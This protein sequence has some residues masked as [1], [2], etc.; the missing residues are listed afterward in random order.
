V[1]QTLLI[2]A[3]L[4]QCGAVA[5]GIYLLTRRNAPAGAWLFLLGAMAS[6]L[7]WRL[8]MIA[9]VTPPPFF[10]PLIAIW[11]S[12][13]MVGAMYLFGREV[14]A[15]HRAEAERDSLLESER[16]A[17]IDA[18]RASRA[19]DEFLA[20][21]SHELRSPLAAILGW[22]AVLR[23]APESVID[24]EHGLALIERNARAQARLIDDL[25]DVTR[26]RSGTFQ[27][28]TE[29][30]HLG[31]PVQAA[32]QAV[33]P[34]AEAKQVAL[35]VHLDGEGPFVLGDVDR[36][37]QVVTN[38]LEN[39]VRF[40]PAGGCVTVSIS[41]RDGTAEL[42]IVDTG[43]GINPEFL[44]HVFERFRQGD[45]STTRRHGGL[46]L[47]LAI[48]DHLVRMHGGQVRAE[49]RGS[50]LGATFIV[51]LPLADESVAHDPAPSQVRPVTGQPLHGLRLLLVDDEDDVRGAATRVLE[52]LGATV[53][54]LDSGEQIRE[55]LTQTRPHALILDIGMPLEDGYSLI[56][57]VRQL[58]AAEGGRTP[59]VSLTAHARNEDRTRALS[60]G[61]DEHLPK[62]IDI[63]RLVST[64]LALTASEDA[65]T[66]VNQA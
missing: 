45:G 23:R 49:S 16:A 51:T 2:I 57:R 17:R 44:P 46:G 53:V 38:L 6:M 64:L 18:E 60:A 7:T 19:K 26:M 40:T 13:C 12:T 25:L 62:P 54:A 56:R 3:A 34:A 39:A 21:L 30:A 5:Y 14:V 61:F 65:R 35:E 31:V 43:E 59:A 58:P 4:L 33:R 36:L 27:L 55:K 47:G 10:T 37:R 22:C 11:G 63:P 52:Q 24:L 28:K 9:G 1:T 29:I 32:V 66:P 41:E 8:V 15:R 42:A 20:T 48:V 50:G